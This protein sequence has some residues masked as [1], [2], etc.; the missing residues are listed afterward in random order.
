[1]VNVVLI[2][3]FFLFLTTPVYSFCFEEAEAMYGIPAELLK[4]IADVESGMNPRAVNYNVSSF[5][6]G[7]MQ[8]NSRWYHVIGKDRWMQLSDPCY[9]VMVGA[10]I[11]K[12]CILK[13]GYTWK[14]VG[15]YHSPN[16]RRQLYYVSLVQSRLRK[17]KE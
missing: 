2:P 10:W 8:I 11:L 14:A 9:N 5:D 16:V 13:H 1:M 15:C 4:A 6:Y 12:Q 7:L 17:F 3:V